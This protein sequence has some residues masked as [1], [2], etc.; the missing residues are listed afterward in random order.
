MKKFRVITK[1]KPYTEMYSLMTKGEEENTK[2]ALAQSL[3]IINTREG[4]RERERVLGF[5]RPSFQTR[6]HQSLHANEKKME[7]ERDSY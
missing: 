7:K 4:E 6:K 3:F 1:K 2:A 5:L